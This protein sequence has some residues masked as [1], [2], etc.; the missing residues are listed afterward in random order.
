[1]KMH[2]LDRLSMHAA[3]CLRDNMKDLQRQFK[4]LL[5][6]AAGSQDCL[7]V[8]KVAAMMMPVMVVAMVVLFMTVIM[9]VLFMTVIMAVLFMVRMKI[10][11][12]MVMI[13]MSLIQHDI[14]IARIQS[15]LFHSADHNIGS[16]QMKAVQRFH[17]H[18]LIR[19]QIQKR[20]D[21]HIA[22]DS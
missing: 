6:Q 11:H 21:G 5:C 4:R 19:S 13:L 1:M 2:P 3:L 10:S 8:R 17:Q 18:I 14:K 16:F 7:D 9:V 15:R 22:A 20:S 12:V